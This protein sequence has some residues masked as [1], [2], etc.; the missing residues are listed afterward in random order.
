MSVDCYVRMSTSQRA[1]LPGSDDREDEDTIEIQL[2][3]AQYEVLVRAAEEAGLESAGIAMERAT[4]EA[5][6]KAPAAHGQSSLA[7]TEPSEGKDTP[8]LGEAQTHASREPAP[9]PAGKTPP[10]A[11]PTATSVSPP[12]AAGKTPSAAKPPDALMP[13]AL[14]AKGMAG[15]RSVARLYLTATGVAILLAL[16]VTIAYQLGARARSA[17]L[18]PPVQVTEPV[19][20]TPPAAADPL[21]PPVIEEPAST[22]VRFTNPF[23][24]AEVFE[25][26]PGTSDTEARDAVAALLLKRAQERQSSTLAHPKRPDPSLARR[27]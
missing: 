8:L 21:A 20:S 9:A 3:P 24:P 15:L 27:S 25:F 2:S 14:P 23:D 11:Q 22:P 19:K 13:S 17:P 1:F 4:P 10:A 5:S 6:P 16:S 7:K 18:A 26:E 12:A